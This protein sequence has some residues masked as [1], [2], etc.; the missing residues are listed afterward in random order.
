[1]IA[2]PEHISFAQAIADML[3]S[4][5]KARG[6]GRGAR[7]IPYIE[8]TITDGRAV[9]A[10]DPKGN[11]AG[12]CYIV[13]FENQRFVAHSGLVVASEYRSLNLGKEIKKVAF[14]LSRTCYPFA[15]VV[16]ITTTPAV[17]HINTALGYKPV[18][19]S[20]IPA[21]EAFWSGCQACPNHDI[22]QRTARRFC[23]CTAM[24]Y[25]PA[26]QLDDH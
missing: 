10:L 25:D 19:F 7:P 5:A 9:I 6:T 8:Q 23:L 24:L 17:M 18:P 12:F 14:E 2:Q 1:M 22:L 13:P 26:T 3:E 16:G 11:L 4:S 21:E 15:K 20:A